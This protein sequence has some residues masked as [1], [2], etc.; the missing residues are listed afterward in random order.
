MFTAEEVIRLVEN[1]VEVFKA[2]K[3][4]QKPSFGQLYDLSVKY[5][6][7]ILVHSDSDYFPEKLYMKRAPNQTDD[8]LDY[9]RNNHK[10]ITYP[11]FDKYQTA[12]SR[13]WNDANWS[14]SSWGE[15][16]TKFS[17]E[18]SPQVYFEEKYP[19]FGSLESYYKT[20]VTELKSKDPNALIVHKPYEIPIKTSEDGTVSFTEDGQIIPDDSQIIEPIAFIYGCENVIAYR[21]GE[22]ALV[23][24][25][26]NSTVI[27][28]KNKEKTGLVFEFYDENNIYTIRQVGEKKDYKFE[29][30]L[31]WTHNLGYLPCS[32]LKGKP[33]YVKEELIYKSYFMPACEPL[34]IA[35]LDN[36]Y[37]LISKYR[38]AFPQKWEYI[39][40]C[41][42]SH[43]EGGT[44]DKGMIRMAGGH[45]VK[46][47]SCKGTGA[48]RSASPF[49][50]IQVPMPDSFNSQA[51]IP[52]APW[53]GF[54]SPD[55]ET[56]E[57]LDKQIDKNLARGLSI[58]NLEKSNDVVKGG[59][60]ALKSQIDREEMFSFLLNISSQLFGLFSFSLG[61]IQKM[62]YGVNAKVP[63]ISEPKN[64]SIRT[65]ADLTD[66]IAIAKK[67]GL[68]DVVI[69]QLIFEYVNTR[70]SNSDRAN[71][72]IDLVF[73][74]DRIITLS[75]LEISQKIGI[76][77]VAKWEDILHTSIYM[78]ID[79]K[80]K[81]EPEFFDKEFMDQQSELIEM[82][83][84]KESEISPSKLNP[85]NILSNANAI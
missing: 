62:R 28:G 65:E 42:Y 24:T 36:A 77:T 30:T 44:C 63:E 73:A 41:E 9:V 11:V 8:E 27:V 20:I 64:F 76:G 60:T 72:I 35:L 54:I 16:D 40:A 59:D 21:Q 85:D 46:C 6:E 61:T 70:F 75:P 10:A 48:Q 33:A 4:D 12:I 56:P 19:I 34:D 55:I 45:S 1:K 50:T 32:K 57:F 69:R 79:D 53:A 25:H 47:P 84:K 51:P 18:E 15:V 67:E 66:E 71:K 17:E 68:P 26:E 81:N 49:H 22:Y 82:A 3:K 80:I 78:W 7:R 43:P 83:K 37:L 74:T 29:A 31:L 23:L 2:L 52:S 14:V 38:H 58:L 39:T 13:V 5:K